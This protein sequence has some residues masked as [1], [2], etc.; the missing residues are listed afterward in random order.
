[1]N[2]KT[3]TAN[4]SKRYIRIVDK[5]FWRMIDDISK[6][7]E[8]SKS[9][10]RIINDALFYGLPMLH[11]RLFVPVDIPQETEKEETPPSKADEFCLQV[12][13]LLKE[14]ILTNSINRSM[15]TSIFN[16]FGKELNGETVSGKRFEDGAYAFTPDYLELYEIRG[17]KNIRQSE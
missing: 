3:I 4:R 1:M 10:N 14:I 16:V 7:E 9:F 13:K 12:V 6:H 8:Y 17:L 11:N 15:L 5:D 2:E